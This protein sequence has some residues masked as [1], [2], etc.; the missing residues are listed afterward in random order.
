VEF[1]EIDGS[2]G[3]GG[4]QIL[5]TALTLSVITA[6]PVRVSRIRAGREVPGLRRQHVSSL[7]VLAS[8][9]DCKLRGATEGSQEVSFVPG[10]PK[11]ERISLDMKTA[12]SITLV[13]QAVVPAAAL[14][15][16]RL[17]LDLV[18]GT[19]VPWSPTFDYYAEDV[20]SALGAVGIRFTAE[21]SRRGYYPRGGGRASVTVEPC[22]GLRP[23]S[24]TRPSDV[25]TVHVVSRCA[26]LPRG[27]AERQ[28]ASAEAALEAAGIAVA[29]RR[30]AEETSDS[31]GS[32]VLVSSVGASHFV[33]SDEL[34]ARGK[35]AEEVGQAAALRFAGYARAG[36]TVDDN[37]ADML[38][39]LLALAP[40]P[41]T[42]RAAK[43]S[44]HLRTSLHTAGLFRRFQSRVR[45]EGGGTVIEV[46]PE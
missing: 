9:F 3:E 38:V 31:P 10:P 22:G 34:G 37:L 41:S 18:G 35:P 28:M 44:E 6:T 43:A 1:L 17:T 27:V 33:G 23:L 46:T 19:D 42:V 30:V 8:V 16:S 26:L 7:G 2:Y 29:E 14:S 40:G 13:L 12:A 11:A 25:R 24:L 15:G 20:R 32:S 4:G 45:G 36:A 21:A 5:R 39:P